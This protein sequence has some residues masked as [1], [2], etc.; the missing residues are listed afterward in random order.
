MSI[1]KHSPKRLLKYATVAVTICF[2]SFF[3]LLPAVSNQF[4][5]LSSQVTAAVKQVPIYK[6][7]T[8]EKKMAISFDATW[9][10]EHTD[11]ILRT[12]SENNVKSTFFLVNIWLEDYPDVAKRITSQGHEIGMHSSTHPHFNELDETMIRKEFMDNY[13][14]IK[15]I[16]GYDATLFRFPFGEY[17]NRGI[18]IARELGFTPV[19]WSID[20]LDWQDLSAAEIESRVLKGLEPGAIVLFHNN[21]LHT[22]EALQSLLP[23]IISQGYQIV[24]ISEL[25]LKGDTYIDVNG[26]QHLKN[27]PAMAGEELK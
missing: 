9:G 16:T 26:I 4:N 23:Q 12:L 10:A 27:N 5:Y 17:N 2:I 14:M 1:Y 22:A 24:P 6:V 21:G 11:N 15:D 20:S 3:S 19:Q 7:D 18:D 25:L 8:K 13:Q